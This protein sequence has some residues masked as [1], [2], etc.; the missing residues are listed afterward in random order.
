MPQ[1]RI[2]NKF[3]VLE[4]P[5]EEAKP[6]VLFDFYSMNPPLQWVHTICKTW[7]KKENIK[8]KKKRTK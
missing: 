4:E 5:K 3:T 6:H 7:L 2:P 8:K 1:G